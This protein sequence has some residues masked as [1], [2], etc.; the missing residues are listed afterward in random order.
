MTH[1]EHGPRPDHGPRALSVPEENKANR[2]G[3][4]QR[5]RGTTMRIMCEHRVGFAAVSV[6]RNRPRSKSK[7]RRCFEFRLVCF[8]GMKLNT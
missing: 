7:V 3:V 5:N 8:S 2:S 4:Y 6:G 1:S